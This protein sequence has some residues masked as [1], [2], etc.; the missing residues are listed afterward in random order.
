MMNA[1]GLE[2]NVAT[3]FVAK[4]F[5]SMRLRDSLASTMKDVRICLLVTDV[6]STYLEEGQDGRQARLTGTNGAANL[7]MGKLLF[8][9]QK[10][11]LTR[12]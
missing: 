6:V 7:Q 9:P 12:R 4:T 1:L 2:G 8:H 3:G 5:T 11:S 10:Q